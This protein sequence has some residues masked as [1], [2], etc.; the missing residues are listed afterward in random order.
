MKLEKFD[1]SAK[2]NFAKI[3]LREVDRALLAKIRFTQSVSKKFRLGTVY[4]SCD[5]YWVRDQQMIVLKV[6]IDPDE[7]Q[8]KLTTSDRGVCV[9]ATMFFE[10]FDIPW[11]TQTQYRVV[12]QEDGMIGVLIKDG[13]AT[14]KLRR[15]NHQQ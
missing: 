15:E 14:W 2:Y 6:F 1:Q 11:V 9:A 13:R 3:E 8:R 12:Q 4:R 10:Q 5:L 7:G